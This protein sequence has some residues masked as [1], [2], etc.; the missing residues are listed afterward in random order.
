MC[1][2]RCCRMQWCL[3]ELRTALLLGKP[4]EVI[5]PPQALRSFRAAAEKA[6]DAVLEDI[7]RVVTRI[8]INHASAS[9][10]E[11]RDFVL[12]RVE[13]T[14]GTE[15]LNNFCR[16]IFRAALLEAAGLAD[17]RKQSDRDDHWREIFEDLL[18]KARDAST[19]IPQ[20]I[21]IERAVAMMQRRI[22]QSDKCSSTYEEGTQLLRDVE[23]RAC[24]FYGEGSELHADLARQL[25]STS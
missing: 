9:F 15:P 21:E 11:D 4:V 7:E 8:D 1:S 24:Q 25:S 19:K 20:V 13:T 5:M 17:P 16:E 2:E 6:K 22:Y 23:V 18:A 3:D 10:R 14:L 12:N